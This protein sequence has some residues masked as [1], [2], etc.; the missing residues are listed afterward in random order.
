[1]DDRKLKILSAVVN[2]YIVTGEPVGSKA[3]MAHVKASSATIRNVI[4]NSHTPPQ[5]EY[6]HIRATGFMLTSSW[7]KTS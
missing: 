6:Q 4:S 7:S 5:A 3:I 2:E 1:M